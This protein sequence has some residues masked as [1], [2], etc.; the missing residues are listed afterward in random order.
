LEYKKLCFVSSIAT[1]GD[2]PPHEKFITEE[3]EW[4]PELPIMIM[5]FLN[6]ERMEVTTR[7]FNRN[8]HQSRCYYW[9][10]IAHTD[11]E[12]VVANFYKS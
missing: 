6:M 10:C 11:W 3:T 12:K 5:L 8:Y 4:N 7:K 2:L 9:S 1:L